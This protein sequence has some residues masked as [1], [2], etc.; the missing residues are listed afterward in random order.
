M[1]EK[2]YALIVGANLRRIANE[3]G[4]TQ[5]DVSKDLNIIKSTVST[6]FR[7]ERCPRMDKIDMLCEYFGV[8]RSD[9]ME[10]HEERQQ[11]IKFTADDIKM[12]LAFRDA[13]PCIQSA[14]KKLLDLE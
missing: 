10:T 7:G 2:D 4:K 5:S 14:I 13:D 1:S 9:I 3:A 12:V 8:N 6:W 11:K